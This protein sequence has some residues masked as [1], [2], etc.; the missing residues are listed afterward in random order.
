M[1][2]NTTTFLA[3]EK[4]IQDGKIT[5][6]N[7]RTTADQSLLIVEITGNELTLPSN[8][9]AAFPQ[10]NIVRYAVAAALKQLGICTPDAENAVGKVLPAYG[11]LPF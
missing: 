6:I 5:K 4:A 11:E 9:T 3:L 7:I 2:E 8:A 1:E 10:E